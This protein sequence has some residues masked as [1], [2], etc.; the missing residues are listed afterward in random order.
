MNFLMENIP[1]NL[2]PFKDYGGSNSD[3]R[4]EGK[5][6]D[7]EDSGKGVIEINR[8]RASDFECH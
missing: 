1:N 6:G 8:E 4:L 7:H 5:L 2:G 3:I